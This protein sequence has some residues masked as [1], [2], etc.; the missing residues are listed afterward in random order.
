MKLLFLR[1]MG[2]L[3]VSQSFG[4]VGFFVRILKSDSC[5]PQH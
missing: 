5:R 3:Q 2:L 4:D 1:K